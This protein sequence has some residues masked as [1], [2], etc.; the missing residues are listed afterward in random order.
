MD[1]ER[2]KQPDPKRRRGMSAAW[3]RLYDW[4]VREAVG[5]DDDA[6]TPA[7]EAPPVPDDRDPPKREATRFGPKRRN[8]FCAAVVVVSLT[9][10]AAGVAGA[11]KGK[12]TLPSE[13]VFC[14]QTIDHSLRVANNLKDCPEHGLVVGARGITIDLG[15]HRIDGTFAGGTTGEGSTGIDNAA[16]YEGL[17]VRN[18]VLTGFDYG[19]RLL[20]AEENVISGVHARG[21]RYGLVVTLSSDN[22]TLKANNAS[23]NSS[24]G[25][26]LN[27]SANNTVKANTVSGNGSAG[28]RMSGADESALMGND[29]TGNGDDGMNIEGSSRNT[30]TGNTVSGNSGSGIVIVSSFSSNNLLDENVVSGNADRGIVMSSTSD[31]TL[32]ANTVSGNDVYGIRIFGGSG[33]HVLL[34]NKVHENG[35]GGISSSVAG[36]VL[37]K[38]VANRNGFLGGPPDADGTGLGI[39]VPAGTTNA[40]NKA[41]GND[42]PAQCQASDL[43]SCH[44]P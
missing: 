32:R 12:Q 22:N 5:G 17:K 38:N 28:L 16:G 18:G 3:D 10:P 2:R 23:G 15:G 26:W 37:K 29:V 11:K 33:G 41:K 25:I 36:L 42:D 8:L 14:G 9:V 27:N 20:G 1:E 7:A 34:K 19:V 13:H 6:G 21:N 43:T 4:F 31:N 35:S 24:H 44:V 39:D 40:G 30:L